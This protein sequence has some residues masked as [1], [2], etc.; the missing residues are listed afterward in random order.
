MKTNVHFKSYFA[1]FFLEWD[2]F[3]ERVVEEIKTYIPCSVTP[4]PDILA[5]Y[6]IMCEHTVEPSRP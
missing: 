1:Q 6:E 3:Q 2:M 4:P 5:V